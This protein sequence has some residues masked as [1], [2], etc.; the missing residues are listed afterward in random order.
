MNQLLNDIRQAAHIVSTI[1]LEL[2][3]LTKPGVQLSMLD[4]LAERRI[5]ELGA[6]PILKGY[7]PD[8]AVEPFPS[9]ICMSV[10]YE[11][12]HGSH[13]NRTLE[14]GQI[15]TYDLAVKYKS[16]H[17]D[18]AITVPVGQINNQKERLMRYTKR[19]MYAG[20]AQVRAGQKVSAIGNAIENE[21]LKNGYQVIVQYGG[22]AI[23]EKIH[24]K[25]EIPNKYYKED[26]ERFLEEGMVICIEPMMTHGK[27]EVK[28]ATDKWT[29]Y[30]ADGKPVAQ[31]EEMVLV[32]KDGYEVLTNHLKS[33][34]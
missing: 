11:I 24:M 30:V 26:E 14:E 9:A 16:G 13:H 34:E 18:A 2:V 1:L 19:A 4:E 21:A 27:A 29:A 33:Y 22:H 7:K 8:W 32:T 28:I 15:I 12:C 20:I 31:F 5:K 10:D 23:G 25:P 17:A 6:E 3:E